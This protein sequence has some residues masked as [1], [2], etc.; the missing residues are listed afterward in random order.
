MLTAP[1]LT[2]TLLGSRPSLRM[3]AMATTLN[4]SLI[5][6]NAMSSTPRPACSKAFGI[7][8]DGAIGKSTGRVAASANAA[9]TNHSEFHIVSVASWPGEKSQPPKF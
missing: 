3:F 7:A 1:P 8:S 9:K 2:L 6:H 5:S 4:A